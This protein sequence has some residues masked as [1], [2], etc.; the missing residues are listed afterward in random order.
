MVVTSALGE[1]RT[2]AQAVPYAG[3]T[4]ASLARAGLLLC[5]GKVRLKL[6]SLLVQG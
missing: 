6:F 5:L 3:G 4:A 2:P 1:Q